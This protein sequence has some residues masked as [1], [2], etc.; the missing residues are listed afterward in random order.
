MN[1]SLDEVNLSD[2]E[3]EKQSC[4][5]IE[6]SRFV[7]ELLLSM[8][9]TSGDE[10]AAPEDTSST[11]EL[12]SERAVSTDCP[13]FASTPTEERRTPADPAICTSSG[14]AADPNG[15]AK[16]ARAQTIDRNDDTGVG[17][18]V[19][20][21]ETNSPTAASVSSTG[22]YASEHESVATASSHSAPV[23]ASAA[24]GD[25][26]VMPEWSSS[27]R[28]IEEKCSDDEDNDKPPSPT[29]LDQRH[30]IVLPGRVLVGGHRSIAVASS[31]GI[32]DCGRDEM[33]SSGLSKNIH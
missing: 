19:Q 32:S 28:D 13:L 10:H 14:L 24:A 2:K 27:Y 11:Q 29:P 31:A 22:R 26:N 1:R 7:Q 3:K 21:D 8:L 20:A 16:E 5:D 25:R 18:S 6:R 17:N 4:E 23:L 9:G 15:G 33:T 30:A 12:E